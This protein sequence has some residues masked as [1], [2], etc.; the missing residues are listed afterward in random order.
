MKTVGSGV[1]APPF[2]TSALDGG[3]WSASRPC[4]FGPGTH[5]RIGWVGPK[6]GLGAMDWRKFLCTYRES[7]RR[8]LLHELSYPGLWLCDLIQLRPA[9]ILAF[10]LSLIVA[11]WY[12]GVG[13][14][15]GCQWG[16]LGTGLTYIPERT[17]PRIQEQG[18]PQ[19]RSLAEAWRGDRG[20]ATWIV[21]NHY[22]ALLQNCRTSAV[23]THY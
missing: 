19:C 3:E 10:V 6:A 9:T 18:G 2:L 11:R 1:I 4:H 5:Y 23:I 15:D 7:D 20:W 13:I 21:W 8:P 16:G 12:G 22:S 14:W 17:R